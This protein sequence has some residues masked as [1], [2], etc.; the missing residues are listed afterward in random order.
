MRIPA[1]LALILS[2]CL[3]GEFLHRIGIPVPGNIL[4]MLILFLLLC[5]KIVREEA[6]EKVSGF[7]LKF[8]PLFFLP[9]G[10]GVLGAWGLL[11]G[12]VLNIFLVCVLS[13]FVSIIFAGLIVQL[14]SRITK[15]SLK[16]E[17]SGEEK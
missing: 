1:Q 5:F 2:I 15:P 4:G 13:S 12:S 11:R 10:V 6:I 16:K 14:L 7:F 8:L 9:A 3:V 17:S